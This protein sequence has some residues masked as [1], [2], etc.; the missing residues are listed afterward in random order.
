MEGHSHY[1]EQKHVNF[2]ERFKGKVTKV[3]KNGHLGV[4]ASTSKPIERV[5]HKHSEVYNSCSF[6]PYSGLDT[7]HESFNSSTL[8]STRM[9]SG[10]VTMNA[11]GQRH[12]Y[13]YYTPVNYQSGYGSAVDN[14]SMAY[15]FLGT[16]PKKYVP[17]NPLRMPDN[18]PNFGIPRSNMQKVGIMSLKDTPRYASQ[19]KIYSRKVMADTMPA[20]TTAAKQKGYTGGGMC[21]A[22]KDGLINVCPGAGSH[23]NYAQNGAFIINQ[24]DK[25][26]RPPPMRYYK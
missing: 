11:F 2:L 3:D 24:F 23:Y 20:S 22:Y 18:A 26:G 14:F 15:D 8:A 21:C 1:S 17:V 10:E 5:G 9:S 6:N 4:A 25:L 12:D 19:G 16:E 13:K 7:H